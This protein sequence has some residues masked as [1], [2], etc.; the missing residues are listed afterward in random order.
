MVR[1]NTFVTSLVGLLALLG[2]IVASGCGQ[3]GGTE[4]TWGRSFS[5]LI[6]D[7]NGQP[8]A[9]VAVEL[10]ETGVTA[11]TDARGQFMLERVQIPLVPVTFQISGAQVQTAVV[12]TDELPQ[13]EAVVDFSIKVNS[14][15]SAEI[16]NVV[17]MVATPTPRPTPT[18]TPLPATPTP[19][20]QPTASPTATVQVPTPSVTPT[21]VPMPTST[22]NPCIGDLNGDL[23]VDL[24]DLSIM[25]T[26]LN[27]QLGDPNYNPVADL[28][29]DQVVNVFDQS[30]LM[31]HFGTHC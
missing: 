15:T 5:G 31:S 27:T 6:T 3:G 1:Q 14:S 8:Q 16:Q 22:P 28:T 26:A 9:N 4:G 23:L 18:R 2:I 20:S 17:V 7:S 25:L 19:G 24:S 10:L 29:G 30:I 11:V 21:A 12:L 13:Q